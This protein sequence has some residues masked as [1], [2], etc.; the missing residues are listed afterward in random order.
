VDLLPIVWEG[1]MASA[2]IIGAALWLIGSSLLIAG[3]CKAAKRGDQLNQNN[4]SIASHDG[5]HSKY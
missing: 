3:L 5:P 4:E 2:L 1:A